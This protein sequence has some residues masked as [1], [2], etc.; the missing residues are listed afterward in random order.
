MATKIAF[1]INPYGLRIKKCCASCAHA[2]PTKPNHANSSESLSAIR[3]CMCGGLK[4]DMSYYC[5]DGGFWQMKNSLRDIHIIHYGKVKPYNVL[6]AR[7][8]KALAIRGK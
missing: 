4:H 1:D 6:M 5:G 8:R 7:L 2:S 3:V